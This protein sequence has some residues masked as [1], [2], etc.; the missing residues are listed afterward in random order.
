MA[1]GGA[2]ASAEAAP[3]GRYTALHMAAWKGRVDATC[4]L[5]IAGATEGIK[6]KRGYGSRHWAGACEP[7]GNAPADAARSNTAEDCAKRNGN[8]A[9]YADGVKQVRLQPAG[10]PA[11]ATVHAWCVGLSVVCFVRV[12]CVLCVCVRA[13]VCACVRVCVFVCVSVCV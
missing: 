8:A 13:C 9:A 11:G 3:Y 1:G 7:R 2:P 10:A 5:L 12:L 6:N 4:A